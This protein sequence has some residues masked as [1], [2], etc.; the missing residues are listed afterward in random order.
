MEMLASPITENPANS[1]IVQFYELII[2][3]LN[4]EIQRLRSDQSKSFG[5][6]FVW[7]NFRWA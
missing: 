3:K 5:V 7:L 6:L 1:R 2:Y 4:E